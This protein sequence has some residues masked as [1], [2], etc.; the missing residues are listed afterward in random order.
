MGLNL[1]HLSEP[2]VRAHMASAFDEEWA[3]H[4]A[5]GSVGQCYG[6]DLTESGWDQWARA[7]PDALSD[8]DDDWLLAQMSPSYYWKPVRLR[9]RKGGGYSQ[10]NYNLGDALRVLCFGEFNV[11][12]VRGLARALVLRG[13][14]ECEVYRAGHAAEPRSECSNW[15]G[16]RFPLDQVL[17]G[18]RARYWPVPGDRKAWSVPSGPN[19]HHSIRATA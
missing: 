12:Y 6:K 15:E 17:D 7:M 14:T 18:H 10:V 3:E 4:T 1:E 2:D 19:C 9:R 5:E 8:H 16:L 13:E 11:A